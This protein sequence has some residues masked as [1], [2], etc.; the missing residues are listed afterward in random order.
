MFSEAPAVVI[1]FLA[2]SVVFVALALRD[3][4]KEKGELTPARKTWILISFI[5]AAVAIGLFVVHTFLA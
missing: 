3:Y 2:L 1:V 5:F 4:L